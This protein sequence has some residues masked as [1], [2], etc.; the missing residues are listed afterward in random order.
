ME[1]LTRRQALKMAGVTALGLAA[2]GRLNLAFA[3]DE[4]EEGGLEPWE[5]F[6]DEK[7]KIEMGN[8]YFQVEGKEKNAPIELEVGKIYVLEFKN[9]T[10]VE[11]NAHF[12]RDADLDHR[13]YNELL[14][15][16]FF[17]IELEAG[18]EGEVIVQVPGKPGDWEIGCFITGHYEAGMVAP[19]KVVK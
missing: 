2:A 4:E 14:I 9:A 16:G 17:G 15:D 10:D 8:F 7:I 18:E 1:K 3:Q 12:G 5:E 19:L 6:A 13:R 11:H